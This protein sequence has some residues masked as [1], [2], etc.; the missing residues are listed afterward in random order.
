MRA[1]PAVPDDR[2]MS[3]FLASF[4][5]GKATMAWTMRLRISKK[6][7]PFKKKAA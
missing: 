1:I 3:P 5:H 6:R 4:G 2:P 7:G